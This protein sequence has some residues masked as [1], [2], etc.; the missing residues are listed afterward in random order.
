MNADD[1]DVDAMAHADTVDTPPIYTIDLS[2]PPSERYVALAKEYN[3]QVH[4]LT[5]L[6]DEVVGSIVPNVSITWIKRLARVFLTRL[7]TREETEE[8]RGVSRATGVD[9]FLLVA[10]NVLLDLL[11]GCSSGAAITR[12]KGMEGTK[13]L[14]FR[15][16]D[17]GM[18]SLRKVIVQL[19]F[20]RSSHD[21]NE[22]LATSI[23]Y[24]G[25]VGVLTGVRKNLSI[26]LNFRPNHDAST[27]M[28]NFRFYSHHL[29]VL[30]GMRQSI[31]SLLRKYLIPI[32]TAGKEG[33]SGE[34]G[35]QPPSLSYVSRTLPSI[36]TTAC[37]L[38][39]SD[40]TTTLSLEKDHNTAV[41]RSSTSFIVMTNHDL[42]F[43][44]SAG[45]FQYTSTD[46]HFNPRLSAAAGEAVSLA[47]AIAES[48]DRRDCMVANWRR[49]VRQ[50]E[51]KAR[52]KTQRLQQPPS[53]TTMKTRSATKRRER[54]DRVPASSARLKVVNPDTNPDRPSADADAEI[55][56]DDFDVTATKQEVVKWLTAWPITNETTHFA[57]VM[58]PMEGKVVW[59][60]RYLN[61]VEEPGISSSEEGEDQR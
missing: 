33:G 30:L 55:E 19:E 8:I 28:T 45:N 41:T 49:K 52:S 29:L 1:S 39:F 51:R 17:W 57:A 43:S 22:V 14:H 18:D 38:T 50:A 35:Q 23:G 4:S 11:M 44:T 26:S 42:E 47:D 25:F 2:L 46:P 61:A 32:P 15:T 48:T 58:D 37:Y 16:L 5:G 60:R 6:F 9:F 12:E 7:Y 27:R 53:T 10:F 56:T 40:G 59:V 21:P 34:L 36:P 54:Q 20:I 24:V 31:S 3:E 13:M